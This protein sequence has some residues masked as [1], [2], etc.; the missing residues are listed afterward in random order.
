[1]VIRG[2]KVDHATIQ[3]WVFKFRPLLE[4]K[5]K[6]RIK[7]GIRFKDFESAKSTLTGIERVHMI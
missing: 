6:K 5:C 4:K 3:V 7:V 2:V 1:M